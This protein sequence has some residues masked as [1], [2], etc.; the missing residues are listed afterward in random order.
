MLFRSLREQDLD[1]I[2]REV[3]SQK[4][5]IIVVSEEH[6]GGRELAALGGMG[7]IL[8]YKV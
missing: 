6:D 4:G 3:E 2:V 1:S 7:A 8:R 5:K